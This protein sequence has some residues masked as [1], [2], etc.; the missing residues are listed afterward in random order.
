MKYEEEKRRYLSFCGSY[1]HT[2][3]WFTGRIRKVSRAALDMIEEYDGFQKLFAGRVDTNNLLLGL[4]LL[5][6]SGICSGC[7]AE[8]ATRAEDDRCQIRQCC[9]QKGLDLC[10]ECSEF[11]CEVLANNP[12]VIK[13]HCLENLREIREKGLQR[14]IDRQWQ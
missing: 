6:Q 1:C 10:S 3:D 5:A 9:S 11:P 14:W 8:I 4:K 2:C 7:K 12:G 13:F